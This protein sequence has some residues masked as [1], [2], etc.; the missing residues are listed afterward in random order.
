MIYVRCVWHCAR[1]YQWPKLPSM[2]CS[3]L[4]LYFV[5]FFSIK[6][7]TSRDKHRCHMRTIFPRTMNNDCNATESHRLKDFCIVSPKVPSI[8]RYDCDDFRTSVHTFSRSK[9][10]DEQTVTTK[11]MC[12][13]RSWRSHFQATFRQFS[14]WLSKWCLEISTGI[15]F[16]KLVNLVEVKVWH[17]RDVFEIECRSRVCF[18][19]HRRTISLRKI[20][21]KQALKTPAGNVFVFG[22]FFAY[23]YFAGRRYETLPL[24]FWLEQLIDFVMN[25]HFEPHAKVDLCTI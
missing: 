24:D 1:Y 17:A 7:I 5:L 6:Y 20:E 23:V 16:I 3:Q 8:V 10:S 19:L 21:Q 2:T 4:R 15:H 12:R 22:I 14:D 9:F 18:L 13:L 25:S 11:S